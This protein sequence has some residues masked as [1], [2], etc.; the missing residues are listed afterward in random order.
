MEQSELSEHPAVVTSF[1]GAADTQV[2][3]VPIWVTIVCHALAAVGRLGSDLAEG[4]GRR[5]EFAGQE[6]LPVEPLLERRGGLDH[7]PKVCRSC[8]EPIA[9]GSEHVGCEGV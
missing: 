1:V 7:Q 9:N 8:R 6:C 3:H 2:A 4:V 5:T